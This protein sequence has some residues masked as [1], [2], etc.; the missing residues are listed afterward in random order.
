MVNIY[1]LMVDINRIGSCRSFAEAALGAPRRGAD[2]G[3]RSRQG[4]DGARCERRLLRC[5]WLRP[6]LLLTMVNSY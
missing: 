6:E 5:G 3:T 2:S 4:R 1:P